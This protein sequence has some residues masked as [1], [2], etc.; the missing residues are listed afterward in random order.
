VGRLQGTQSQISLEV[1]AKINQLAPPYLLSTLGD[2]LNLMQTTNQ[3]ASTSH[4]TSLY[5][6]SYTI[7]CLIKLPY[8]HS[9][10]PNNIILV[11]VGTWMME[12]CM[13][14]ICY[15]IQ[16]I[17][18]QLGIH[19]VPMRWGL[20]WIRRRCRRRVL[21]GLFGYVMGYRRYTNSSLLQYVNES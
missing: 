5:T 8:V 18:N 3:W 9:S 4:G 21:W 19:I 10:L 12:R 16:Q 2:S 1:K 11:E 14:W 20:C 7:F 6:L 17:Q 13:G 15:S